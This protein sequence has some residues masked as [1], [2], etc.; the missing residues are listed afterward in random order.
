MKGWLRI[1][2]SL[3]SSL[4]KTFPPIAL[5]QPACLCS[6]LSPS[7]PGH[8]HHCASRLQVSYKFLKVR[9]GIRYCQANTWHLE[10][11]RC[12]VI[13]LTRICSNQY[14]ISIGSDGVSVFLF[15]FY[16]VHGSQL[17]FLLVT[18]R[19]PGLFKPFTDSSESCCPSTW[20]T[21]PHSG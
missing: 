15:F 13:Y 11:G 5:Q 7:H 16:L 14:L 21:R 9:K 2:S 4:N 20:R 10:G 17:F 12:M 8:R 6:V 3:M 19:T 1:I 18:L